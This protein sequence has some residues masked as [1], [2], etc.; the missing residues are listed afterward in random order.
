MIKD[1][2]LGK[3]IVITVAN[4][5][6]ILAD[7]SKILADHG[8]NLEA[9]AGYT[10]ENEAR[11][12]LV[13]EDN[14]RAKDALTKAG[15]KAAKENPVLMLTLENKTGALKLLAAKLASEQIDINY[16]Y[17]TTCMSACP[18]RLILSTNNNE[19]A[20]LAFKK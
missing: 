6:G 16:V 20:L 18:A 12:M 9:V 17:G 1:V 5:I 2:Q 10:K 13:T 8:I 3:E 7:L 14:L 4:K 11:I 19:K 15:Y